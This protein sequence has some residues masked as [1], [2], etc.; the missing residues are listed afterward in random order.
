MSLTSSGR[1][2]TL[3]GRAQLF[4]DC[5]P[6]RVTL[7]EVIPIGSNNSRFNSSPYFRPLAFSTISL[8]A[9]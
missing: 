4:D 1:R 8:A 7:A 9:S 3:C 5:S 6:A 2:P